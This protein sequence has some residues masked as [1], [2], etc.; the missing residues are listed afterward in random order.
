MELSSV[1]KV[2]A[3]ETNFPGVEISQLAQKE[4]WRKEVHRPATSTH[5]WWAKRL[6]SVFRGVIQSAFSLPTDTDILNSDSGSHPTGIILDPFAGSGLI[7]GEAIKLG[8]GAASIDINPVATLVERQSVAIWDTAHLQNLYEQLRSTCEEPIAKM[9]SDSEGRPV[10]YYFWVATITCEACS[11]E[12]PLFSSTIYAKH[13]YPSKFPTCQVVCPTCLQV[14]T[15]TVSFKTHACR[16]GHDFSQRGPVTG[17]TV[18]CACGHQMKIVERLDGKRPHYRMFAKLVLDSDGNKAYRGIDEFDLELYDSC[19]KELAKLAYLQD[20]LAVP[21]TPGHNTDQALRWGFK[22]WGDFFNARQLV[23]LGLIL[24][25]LNIIRDDSPEWEALVALFSGMLEFNNMFASYKGEGTG[26]VRHMFSNHVLKPERVPLEAHPWGTSASS[27]AFSTLFRSRLMRADSYKKKPFD[28]EMK[29]G[30]ISRTWTG[31]FPMEK[32]ISDEWPSNFK[33]TTFVATGD[34]TEVDI[35]EGSVDMICTDPPYA[36]NVHYSELADFFHVWLRMLKPWSKYPEVVSTRMK[37]EVQD[38][39]FT[40]FSSG[41]ERV[42]AACHAALKPHGILAF[43]FQHSRFE[44]WNSLIGSLDRA[45]FVVTAMQP[46]KAEMSTSVVKQGA[47]EPSN[48]D[49]IVVCRRKN[50]GFLSPWHSIQEAVSQAVQKLC[51]LRE[52]G[53]DVGS[54]DVRTM[55]RALGACW[56]IENHGEVSSTDQAVIENLADGAIESLDP[57]PESSSSCAPLE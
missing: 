48:L 23:S 32:Q 7:S 31:S 17:A 2:T 45:G 28:L 4:S 10:L 40:V 3:L 25:E 24:K 34:I 49:V 20:S 16:S 21:L 35:P 30:T 29:D 43:S 15:D 6:G 54:G 18:H 8:F 37:N 12:I 42:W 19:E 46:V 44:G 47:K 14:G 27:G 11:R 57:Q 36:N 52:A 51:S 50:D 56:A 22:T 41:I 38:A 5:K 26:A 33:E 39:D 53:I 9:H 55:I 13:A 1:P